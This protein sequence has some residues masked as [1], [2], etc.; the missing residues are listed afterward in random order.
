MYPI[1]HTEFTSSAILFHQTP[2]IPEIVSTGIIFAFTYKCTHFLYHIHPPIPLS[3][4]LPPPIGVS[5]SPRAVPKIKQ[6]KKKISL[7]EIEVAK[8][9]LSL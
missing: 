4:Q 9:K 1:Y 5:L 2:T 8:W 6:Q 7:F 3:Q